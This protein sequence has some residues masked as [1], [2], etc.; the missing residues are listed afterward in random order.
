VLDDNKIA[1][2]FLVAQRST[3]SRSSLH[4]I[5]Q[6]D[7][8]SPSYGEGIADDTLPYD[9]VQTYASFVLVSDPT[10]LAAADGSTDCYPFADSIG[11]LDNYPESNY[12]P[13]EKPN[14]TDGVCAIEYTAAADVNATCDNRLYGLN[15]YPSA[16]EAD[17]AGAVVTH[18]GPCGVCSN[19]EDFTMRMMNAANFQA[20][21]VLCSVSYTINRDFN[22]LVACFR[23][24]LGLTEEC[25][26]LWAHYSDTNA[27]VCAEACASNINGEGNLTGSP[28]EC[29]LSEC[30][31]FSN[32]TF[33]ADFDIL[34]GRT[35][36]HSGI[37][38]QIARPCNGFFRV[39]HNPPPLC[40]KRYLCSRA[41]QRRKIW[42]DCK[43]SC[44]SGFVGFRCCR[45]DVSMNV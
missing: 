24:R 9:T 37:T 2:F 21:T 42:N 19:L 35:W 43:D 33:Q 18:S 11:P 16:E 23:E 17:S 1:Y 7:K 5:P 27:G 45:M 26:K 20:T 6:P 38:E 4:S 10:T 22:D 3:D 34:S 31:Q 44:S 15:S 41:N 36:A 12:P 30:L 25:G 13:C 28:P 29:A 14:S 40:G 32:S 8:S 39:V